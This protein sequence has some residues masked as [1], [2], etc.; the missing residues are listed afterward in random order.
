M[1]TKPIYL[2]KK[3]GYDVYEIKHAKTHD[4]LGTFDNREEAKKSFE[5]LLIKIYEDINESK[6]NKPKKVTPV[7]DDEEDDEEDELIDMSI[8]GTK[9]HIDNLLCK[10]R[11]RKSIK[12]NV[13]GK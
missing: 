11:K 12:R 2:R 8:H 10:S 13:L 5:V 6:N 7:E 1:I 4:V 3:K 9:A